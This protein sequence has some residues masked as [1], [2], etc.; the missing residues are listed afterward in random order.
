MRDIMAVAG[1]SAAELAQFDTLHGTCV[2]YHA[3]TP[4]F[5]DL[6][7]D[8][9]CGLSMY[10]PYSG[11]TELNSFYKELDWNKATDFVL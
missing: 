8:R 1:A 4:K 2:K 6:V 10:L 9:C 5:F 7:L 11:W 3:E